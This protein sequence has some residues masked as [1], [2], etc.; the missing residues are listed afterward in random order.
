V[1]SYDI[2]EQIRKTFSG[3]E[4][5]LVQYLSRYL[6]DEASEDDDILQVAH[7]MLEFVTMGQTGYS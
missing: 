3:T 2:A 4:D 6:V 7:Y 1:S 5:I